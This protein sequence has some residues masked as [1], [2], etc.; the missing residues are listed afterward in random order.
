MSNHQAGCV[1]YSGNGNNHQ[2]DTVRQFHS[3]NSKT[4][5]NWAKTKLGSRLN[6]WAQDVTDVL[7][8]TLTM[9]HLMCRWALTKHLLSGTRLDSVEKN[10]VEWPFRRHVVLDIAGWQ[11]CPN[12]LTGWLLETMRMRMRCWWQPCH[13]RQSPTCAPSRPALPSCTP[14]RP[15]Y[16]VVNY[17]QESCGL[18]YP[19]KKR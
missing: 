13:K 3:S 1:L 5:P 6:L 18:V 11:L 16:L 2:V 4:M 15:S 10:P 8:L 9:N 19:T 12:F 7:I 14:S 17:P